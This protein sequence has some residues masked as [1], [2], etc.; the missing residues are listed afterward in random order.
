MNFS[1]VKILFN[2]LNESVKQLK[3]ISKSSEDIIQMMVI[4]EKIKELNHEYYYD[5]HTKTFTYTL[6]C[7]NYIPT[8]E[9]AKSFV[10]SR[11]IAFKSLLI[12]LKNNV[13]SKDE[14]LSSKIKWTFI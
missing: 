4:K 1:E 8:Y 9:M 11:S 2:T 13:K 7:D 3:K 5:N 6:Y 10:E 14:K 12:L